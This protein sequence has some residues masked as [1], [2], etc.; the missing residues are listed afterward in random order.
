MCILPNLSREREIIRKNAFGKLRTLEIQNTQAAH[1]P[2]ASTPSALLHRPGK[3]SRLQSTSVSFAIHLCVV[4]N[5]LVY[6]LQFTSVSFA[7]Y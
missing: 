7:I 4:C 6:R 5:L 3:P 1:S 2:M